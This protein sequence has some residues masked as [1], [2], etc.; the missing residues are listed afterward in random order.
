MGTLR[1]TQ[2]ASEH[3]FERRDTRA[4]MAH[5][6]AAARGE[7]K[8]KL[9]RAILRQIDADRIAGIAVILETF[10]ANR[11]RKS[12]L[13]TFYAQFEHMAGWS[14]ER[15]YRAL[16][17]DGALVQDDDVIAREFDAGQQV[18]REDQRHSLA[19]GD[20]ANQR[21]HLV[22]SFRV[23]PCGRLAGK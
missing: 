7:L 23:H 4:Q 2:R 15:S 17:G 11:V 14:L 22:A 9:R 3:V 16:R 6:D 13:V 10:G 5:L 12:R 20:V 1:L 21:E 19:S 18:R 8:Q